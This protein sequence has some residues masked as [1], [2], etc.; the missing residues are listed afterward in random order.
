ME[1]AHFRY[2]VD[3]VDAAIDF[4]C[5][6]L[7]FHCDMHPAPGFAALSRGPL[8]LYL[9]APG[10]GGAGQSVGGEVPRPG[11]W[12]R[13]QVVVSDVGSLYQKLVERGLHFRGELVHGRGGD[14][15]LLEDPSGN[16]VEL[17][18]P[19]ERGAE[20]VPAEFSTVTPFIAV[21]DVDA[22]V[23]FVERAFGGRLIRRMRSDDGVTRH[24]TVSI[25]DSPIMVSS[26]TDL[27]GRR[28]ATLHLYVES[29]DAVYA[30]A[31]AAGATSVEEPR[32]E[33][34]GDRRAGV[35]DRWD[36]HWWIATHVEDVD[37]AMLK[38]REAEFR[39]AT[40]N[41]D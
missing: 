34:Y 37:D 38:K 10:A 39:R 26:G 2:I 9:N 15:V 24:A 23:R 29:A 3:D 25:G 22:F 17:F 13:L 8:V 28:P 12:S 5:R 31:I 6:H 32:M 16:P 14:Q 36:N 40:E 7:D 11:G 21:D 30:R 35:R 4:Y 20:P 33:F 18:E 41:E 1:K 19:R 27:Y